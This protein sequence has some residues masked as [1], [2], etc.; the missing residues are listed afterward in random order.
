MD[1]HQRNQDISRHQVP[2]LGK[3]QVFFSTQRQRA[4]SRLVRTKTEEVPQVILQTQC[5]DVTAYT[6]VIYCVEYLCL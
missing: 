3:M 1:P 4:L 5:L 2:S 6:Q